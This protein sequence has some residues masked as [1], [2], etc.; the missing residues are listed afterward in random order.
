MVEVYG[1]RAYW[2]DVQIGL[3]LQAA[4][5]NAGMLTADLAKYLGVTEEKIMAFCEGL[6]RM[7]P[8]ILV[9]S[10]EFLGQSVVWFF[11]FDPDHNELRQP[12]TVYQ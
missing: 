11:S 7:S 3:R 8:D 10:S 6:E 1:A 12:A 9:R 5:E 2:V 4:L